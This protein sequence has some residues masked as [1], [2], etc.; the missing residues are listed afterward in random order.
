MLSVIAVFLAGIPL[1]ALTL[2]WATARIE[3]NP[4]RYRLEPN[5]FWGRL[6]KLQDR[7]LLPKFL[8]GRT[9]RKDLS[10]S[11]LGRK[12]RITWLVLGGIL[13]VTAPIDIALAW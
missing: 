7:Y 12:I 3:E 8:Q 4:E 10:A 13:L 5:G 2:D 11:H 1:Q 6:Q 9:F